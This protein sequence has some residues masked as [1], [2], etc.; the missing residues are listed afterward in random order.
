ME[1]YPLTHTRT[2]EFT[3]PP[4][5]H[6]RIVRLDRSPILVL[7]DS[8]THP[9]S[10]CGTGPLT[11]THIVGLVHPPI[12]V[13]WDWPI[14]P[15]TNGG[16]EPPNHCYIYI[17]IPSHYKRNHSIEKLGMHGMWVCWTSC[18]LLGLLDCLLIYFLPVIFSYS[19]FFFLDSCQI[20]KLGLAILVSSAPFFPFPYPTTLW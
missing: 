14:H 17:G 8:N 6:T 18:F 20:K 15:Y 11:H 9:Y 19:N 10:Y 16:S 12:H 7:W 3:H 1:S 13:L 2:E 5:T 4:L